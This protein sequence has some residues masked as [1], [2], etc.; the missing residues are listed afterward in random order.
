M[1]G[2]A[3]PP[4]NNPGDVAVTP[5]PSRRRSSSS[6]SSS[7]SSTSSSSSSSSTSVGRKRKRSRRH[8]HKKSKRS[9]RSKNNRVNKLS[10]EIEE[11]RDLLGRNNNNSTHTNPIDF[12]NES[13]IDLNESRELFC[14]NDIN[15][16]SSETTK[17]FSFNIQT[18]LKEPSVPKAPSD[19]LNTLN[20]IQHFDNTD[21]CDVRYADTQKM[22]SH[23]PGFVDLE[24]NDEIKAYE[25][26]R[27]L[28]QADRAYAA[29][30]FCLLK[31]REVLQDSLKSFLTWARDERDKLCFDNLQEKVIE[32]FFKG[33]VHK[34]SSDLLQLLCGHR[35]EIIQMRRDAIL[36]FIRDPLIKSSL[37]K[38]PP[39]CQNLFNAESFTTTL[40]KI[41]GVKKAFLPLKSNDSSTHQAGFNKTVSNNRPPQGAVCYN[42]PSQGIVPGCCHAHAAHPSYNAPPQGSYHSQCPQGYADNYS[43]RRGA[44]NTRGS[45]RSRTGRYNRSGNVQFKNIRNQNASNS[46]SKNDPFKKRRN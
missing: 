20:C 28:A 45:F 5:G 10:K 11:L 32:I 25:S 15:E 9:R 4:E 27:H 19:F 37:R 34:V 46:A 1:E 24:I 14:D 2:R 23:S 26:T 36:K 39:S 22:Y 29:Q 13:C 33:D 42:K 3:I 16:G 6:S 18:K 31:L 21:W 40:E 30:T 17:E 43:N 7:S 12:C 44:S 8:R 41:G 38:I 35:A